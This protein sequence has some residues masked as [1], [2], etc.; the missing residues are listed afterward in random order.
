M[1][2]HLDPNKYLSYAYFSHN[3]LRSDGA[4]G[5]PLAQNAVTTIPNKGRSNSATLQHTVPEI[6][7]LTY[8]EKMF[9]KRQK[10]FPI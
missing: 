9:P 2:I 4:H 3:T 10:A 7:F 1:K 8:T 6:Y 5:L